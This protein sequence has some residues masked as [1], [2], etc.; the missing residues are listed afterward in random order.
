MIIDKFDGRWRFLSNF[1]PC[2]VE[3]DG[4]LYPS[5]EH[6]YVAMKIN[7]PQWIKDSITNKLKL[8]SVD[9]AREYVSKISSA[10]QVKRL[11]RDL[12]VRKDWDDIKYGVRLYGVRQKFK[13]ETL[14]QMLLETEDSELIEGNYWHDIYWG[15]CSCVKCSNKG[16]NNLGKVLMQVRKELGGK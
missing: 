12:E 15:V 8:Y 16:Q 7:T 2:K 13:D 3:K 9:D 11:G 10:G 5:N 1:H 14:K 4:I 6:F